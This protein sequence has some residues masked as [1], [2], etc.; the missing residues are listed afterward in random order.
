M[1]IVHIE[2]IF[3]P[4]YGYQVQ[5]FCRVHDQDH[6]V[7]VIAADRVR[8]AAVTETRERLD[9]LD[10]IYEAETGVKIHRLRCLFQLRQKTWLSGLGRCLRE[11]GPDAIYAHGFEY[12]SLP[13]LLLGHWDR[14]CVVVADSHDLPSAAH[15]VWLRLIYHWLVLK[16]CV[17]QVNFRNVRCYYVAPPTKDLFLS[18]GVREDLLR[19]LPIGTSP[20]TYSFSEVLRTKLRSEWHVA[21]GECVVIYTGKHD[22]DK[23][24]HLLYE[25]ACRFDLTKSTGL[26]IVSVG[27]RNAR[28]HK[29]VCRPLIDKLA[30]RSVRVIE[31]DAVPSLELPGYYSAAA[32]GVFPARSTL[33]CLDAMA[34]GLPVVMQDDVTNADRLHVGGVVFA[35][36]DTG[37]LCKVMESLACNP[38]ERRELGEKAIL[39]V[40]K[41]FNYR[42]IVKF[43][44]DDLYALRQSYPE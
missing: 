7:H 18:Y 24:P 38:T 4:E 2:E 26:V 23:S 13:R 30:D 12:L 37:A 29:E 28:Y 6:E 40:G 42:H 41:R 31:L 1:I 15:H 14:R 43:L 39:D 9:E 34:C 32:M 27:A 20:E 17:R 3:H 35:P 16:W 36:G 19:S 11:I 8:S 10:R 25:A 33:S 44:E 5:N 22:S 21:D